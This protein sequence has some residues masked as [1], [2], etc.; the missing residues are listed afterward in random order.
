MPAAGWAARSG[1]PVL[2]V[3]RDTV[4]GG[5]REG[6]R[7]PRGDARLRARPRVGDLRRRRSSELERAR[8]DGRAGRRR[9][10]GRE[11]DRVRALRQRQL[12]LEHQRPRPRVRDRDRGAAR[13]TRA[14]RRRS[15][16]AVPGARC[17]SPTTPD[18]VPAELRG[19]LLDLKPGYEDDP[20]RA[21]YNHVWLIG[22]PDAIVGRLPG[23]DRRARRAGPGNV[24]LRRDR[25]GA[26]ARRG[27]VLA[28]PG[29]ARRDQDEAENQ[30]ASS[31]E[32]ERATRPRSA[33][34]RSRSRTCARSPG[35]RPPTSRSRSAT[36]SSA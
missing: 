23:P 8:P 19:Y 29:R 3:G 32:R 16:R 1:D 17:C 22:D 12:R 24:R 25:T 18:A 14:P 36:G 21:L 30:T 4:P 5:D 10:R 34:A 20:T 7:A 6:A 31:D 11:R 27:R 35:P 13:S 33:A 26:R 2:F 28:R 15:R 9:G